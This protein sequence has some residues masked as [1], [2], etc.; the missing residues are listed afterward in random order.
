MI[1]FAITDLESDKIASER[2]A[3]AAHGDSITDEQEGQIDALAT[4]NSND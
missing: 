4:N 3:A 1:Q 2:A